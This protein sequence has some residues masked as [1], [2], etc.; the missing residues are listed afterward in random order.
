MTR[1]PVAPGR[2]A[3]GPGPERKAPE[4]EPRDF[5]KPEAALAVAALG[6]GVL[7]AAV[8]WLCR[9]GMDPGRAG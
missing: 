5:E 7:A 3:V 8:D 6:V 1:V 2:A 9:V 4:F